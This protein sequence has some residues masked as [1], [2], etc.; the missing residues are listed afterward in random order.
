MT[1]RRGILGILLAA[2]IV[3]AVA[4]IVYARSG[5][6]GAASAAAPLAIVEGE[7]L[8]AADVDAH[9]AGQLAEI[10]AQEA[11]IREEALQDLIDE[12]LLAKAAAARGQSLQDY[13]RAEVDE[14]VVVT[15]EEKR[16]TFERYRSELAGMTEPEAM[17]RVEQAIAAQKA[18]Q[19]REA[20]LNRVRAAGSV[21]M[22]VE[23]PRVAV[24]APVGAPSRGP[25]DAPVTIVEFSDFQCPFCARVNET[26]AQVLAHYGDRVRL[27]FRDYP[28]PNHPEAPKAHEAG[29]C[30]A[31]QGRFWP[32]HDRMF[33]DQ[34]ALGVEGLK[35]TAGTLGLDRGRFDACLDSGRHAPAVER[36]M[37]AGK[38][39][40]VSG[41]PAFFVNGRMLTGAQPFSQFSRVIDDELQRKGVALPR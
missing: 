5:Q 25:A 27:V 11:R 39:A 2:A 21:K 20:I 9:A 33:A 26:I 15:D 8:T 32:M 6:S 3:A 12:K 31:E 41:T 19:L 22:L 10:R 18:H 28:L 23:P 17:A 1:S 40:G 30:A 7:T 36:D 4:A 24:E 29:R 34:T 16:A 35:K 13:L 38:S 37:S 14:K